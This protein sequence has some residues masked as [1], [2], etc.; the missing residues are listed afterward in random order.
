[1]K[2]KSILLSTA[3]ISSLFLAGC[4]DD[5]ESFNAADQY[6]QEQE[7]IEAYLQENGL[8]AQTDTTDARLKYIVN[9]TGN[10]ERVAG[11]DVT[12][13]DI[14]GTLLNGNTFYEEDSI[15][16]RVNT[17]IA[18]YYILA[19]YFSVGSDVTMFIPSYYGYGSNVAFDGDLPANTPMRLDVNIR[20]TQSSFDYEQMVI[21][22]YLEDNNLTAE[23]DEETG[24][25]YIIEEEGNGDFPTSSSN[26]TVNYEGTF[27][28]GETFDSGSST[29][30]SLSNLI[31]GW[32][33]LMPYVSEGGTIT[34]FLPSE[35]AYG[36]SGAGTIA[37][38]STLIFTID[39]ESIN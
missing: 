32:Q 19:P 12:L 30:F 24:L 5:D 14:T 33:V 3:L 35:Y 10:G 2:L 18:G 31:E 27:L 23:V 7:E 16:I 4:N 9:Q 38:Y 20:G 29:T 36:R 15:Y 39:L 17:W 11:D 34:M 26:V 8:N 37:P 6:N 22:Q 1:M 13:V 21:S 28:S 25:R